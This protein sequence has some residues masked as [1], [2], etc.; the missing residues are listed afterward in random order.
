[1][2][3]RLRAL[4]PNLMRRLNARHGDRYPHLTPLK[5]IDGWLSL[6]EADLLYRLARGVS[7]DC[8]V[9]IGSYR[10]RSTIA[11]ALGSAAGHNVK[12]YAIDPHEP[13]KGPLGGT[14]GPDDRA[15]FFHNMLATKCYQNVSLVNLSSE[16]ISPGWKEP[17]ALLWID[18]DHTMMGVRRDLRC[19]LPYL[20]EDGL[21]AFDDSL[22]PALGP[23]Q[24]IDDLM[25]H[26]FKIVDRLGKVT[27]IEQYKEGGSAL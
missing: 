10:G 14:F 24:V 17:V 13:F 18:G 4:L 22:D 8:I 3:T 5:S 2:K 7:H 25:R 21:I 1:M 11:L 27:V 19:W 23:F 16:I 6:D 20:T 12:I 26:G 15:T 9:E